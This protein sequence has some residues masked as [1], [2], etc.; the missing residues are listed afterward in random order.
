MRPADIAAGGRDLHDIQALLIRTGAGS[1]GESAPAYPWLD[2]S[3][4][5]FLR[6]ECPSLRLLGIDTLSISSPLQREEGRACHR[7]FLCGSSPILLL[8]DLDLTPAHIVGRAWRLRIFPWIRAQLDGV[9]VMAFLEEARVGVD[10]PPDPQGGE[11]ETG[12][13]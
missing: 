11:R 2:P 8:E 3:V 4:P 6:K 1:A 13:R 9:P 12:G 5:T 10:P 7:A